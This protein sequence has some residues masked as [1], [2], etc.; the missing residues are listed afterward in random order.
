[1]SGKITRLNAVT[2]SFIS[3]MS[4]RIR[5]GKSVKEYMD[6]SDVKSVRELVKALDAVVCNEKECFIREFSIDHFHDSK[7][8]QV[9]SVKFCKILRDEISEYEFFETEELL[10]EY[11]IYHT[12]SYVYLKGS[13]CLI[14]GDWAV[15][16]DTFP[17]GLGVALN[18]QNV[19]NL[20][21][22]ASKPIQAV[23]TVENL[24]TFFDSKEKTV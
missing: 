23:V 24:T 5:C 21:I 1:M 10:L 14:V 3:C 4:E 9:L 17:E 12:P 18:L 2:E 13:A 22:E 20:R 11:Q 19:K 8:F 16:A 6:I 7:Q 15:N